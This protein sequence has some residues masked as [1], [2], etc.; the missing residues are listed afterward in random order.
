MFYCTGIAQWES[1][2]LATTRIP[3]NTSSRREQELLTLI[4][5]QNQIRSHLEVEH[6]YL[7]AFGGPC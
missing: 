6:W 4:V 7:I 3:A 2:G 1:A 5:A